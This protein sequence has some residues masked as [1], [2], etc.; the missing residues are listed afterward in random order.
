MTLGLSLLK[1]RF[2]NSVFYPHRIKWYLYLRIP[3]L[4]RGTLFIIDALLGD[5][6]IPIPAPIKIKGNSNSIKFAL[7]C[8]WVRNR[9]PIPDMN[10]PSAEK[11]RELYLSDN[12]PLKGPNIAK[13]T[14]TGIR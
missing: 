3:P 7:I 2:L 8:N 4:R 9:K 13:V 10:K 11:K 6:N 1:R 14:N 5:A 12:H